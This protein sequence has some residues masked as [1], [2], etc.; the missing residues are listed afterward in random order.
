M[1][2][3]YGSGRRNSRTARRPAMASTPTAVS[4]RVCSLA[5][6]SSSRGSPEITSSMAWP[7]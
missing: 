6:N 3:R 4:C 1:N 5:L 7:E 2:R